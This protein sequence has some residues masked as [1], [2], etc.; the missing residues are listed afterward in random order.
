MLK[1]IAEEHKEAVKRST[2]EVDDSL[3]TAQSNSFSYLR[4]LTSV[5]AKHGKA[6]VTFERILIR[7]RRQAGNQTIPPLVY[8]PMLQFAQCVDPP[9]P[10]NC[11]ATYR[12]TDGT[13]NNEANPLQGASNTAFRRL[14]PAEYEDGIYI[15]IGANQT[16]N[17][18]PFAGPWPSPRLVSNR[19]IQDAIITNPEFS[20]FF[21]VFGQAIALDYTRFGEYDTTQCALSCNNI[22]AN[23]PFCIPISVE[24]NDTTYG[25]DGLNQ[26]NCLIVRR[27]IG[28][29]MTPFNSTFDEARQQI[30]QITHY[31]DASGIYGNNDEEATAVRNFTY[32]QLRQ[33]ARTATY[34][35]DLPILPPD[36]QGG[37]T[38][39]FFFFAGDIRVENYVHQINMYVLWYRL[40]NYI[41]GQLAEINP[42]W[43][44]ERLFQEGRKIVV[45][46]W[47]VI[48]YREYL[49]L[50]FGEQFDTYIGNYTGYDDS[51][52]ATVPHSFAT[53]AGRFGHSMFHAETSRLDSEGNMLLV[54]PLGLRESFFNPPEYY[55]GGRLD[56]LV[57]GMLQDQSRE[58][59]QFL[60]IVLTTQ[61]FP[62]PG[63]S[64]GA[65]LAAINIQRAREHGIPPYR[66][67]Q[68]YCEN[69]YSVSTSFMSSVNDTI[70]A[71]YGEHGYTNGIDLWV[72]GLSEEK[73]PGT[74]FG[75][76]FACIV[77]RTYSD[78]RDGDRF[79]WENPSMF[80]DAQRES[81][82]QVTISKVICEN[83]DNITNI[84]SNA[85]L[86]SGDPVSCSSLPS[87]DLSLWRETGCDATTPTT[88]TPTTMIPTTTT[89]TTMAPT[90]TTPTTTTPTTMTPT[91]ANPDDSGTSATFSWSIINIFAVVLSFLLALF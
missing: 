38:P 54:G 76:T 20:M 32:G 5:A 25:V 80:T 83:S 15:P 13:C 6:R 37:P 70:R 26:G 40:H 51:V 4:S 30:N 17:G 46:I 63:A 73:L 66:R 52:D 22:T 72:G 56:P 41:V 11:S 39:P 1:A 62:L 90:T 47:Q 10:Q 50:L 49:P 78:L 7:A 57:R 65:D 23:L 85:F 33:S 53:A 29:C 31:L 9:M 2:D 61:L 87:V 58:L 68:R 28:S 12:S 24:A 89:P 82:S 35:G 36:M 34:K 69:I 8:F 3:P 88:T 74:I 21:T 64:L 75:P 55:T 18:D 86:L 59:D 16:I 48:I 19:I 77:G 14:L 44:D 81:L 84:R 42:C 79:Y 91:T 27:A 45:A 67:W 43:D 60:T 71:V